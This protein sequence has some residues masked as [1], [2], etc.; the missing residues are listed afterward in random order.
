[1]A[2]NDRSE[3]KRVLKEE[4]NLFYIKEEDIHESWSQCIVRCSD[5]EYSYQCYG[6]E[7]N[8]IFE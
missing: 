6:S 8:N 1:M 5:C 4:I 2:R 3:C 7:N